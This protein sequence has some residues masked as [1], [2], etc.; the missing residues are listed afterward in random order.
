MT[1]YASL[2]TIFKRE[3]ISKLNID[4]ATHAAPHDHITRRWIARSCKITTEL[5]Q[6][7]QA[8][9]QRWCLCGPGRVLNE[10]VEQFDFRCCE[11][12]AGGPVWYTPVDHSQPEYAPAQDTEHGDEIGQ[13]IRSA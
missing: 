12:E 13:A 2:P 10:V 7:D 9:Q 8:A 3:F 6:L 1:V 5:C 11:R 4:E